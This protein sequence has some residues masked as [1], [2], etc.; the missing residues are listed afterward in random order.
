VIA[1]NSDIHFGLVDIYQRWL[2]GNTGAGKEA[3]SSGIPL[4]HPWNFFLWRQKG[5]NF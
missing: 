2:E 3:E 5:I 4:L 1:F